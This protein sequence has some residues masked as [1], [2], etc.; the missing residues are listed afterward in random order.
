MLSVELWG[1]QLFKEPR[2]TLSVSAMAG[3]EMP[4]AF[5]RSSR[6]MLF[7]VTVG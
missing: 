3:G 5:C 1:F 7:V 4:P 2:A 6:G